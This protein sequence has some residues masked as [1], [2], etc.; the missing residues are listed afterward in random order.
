MKKKR[1]DW[2]KA[3]KITICALLVLIFIEAALIID[4]STAQQP[5][6]LV[7]KVTAMQ[8]TPTTSEPAPTPTETP[9]PKPNYFPSLHSYNIDKSHDIWHAKDPSSYITPNNEWVK[10]YS[11]QLFVDY[12]G[13]IKYKNEKVTILVDEKGKKLL[14]GYKPFVN[15]YVYDWEQ[16][17]SGNP[18][19]LAND[20][21]WA[22]ADYYLTHGMKGDC[23]EWANTVTSMM[24]SGEMSVWQEDKLVKQVIPTKAVL[25]YIGG[26]RDGWVEY[27][28]Y[29]KNWITSTSR[30][31]IPMSEAYQSTTIFVEKT[32]EFKSIFEF[33]DKYFRRIV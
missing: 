20:D 11:S 26:V 17:G 10:Y 24:L 29:N 14:D 16:F 32:N 2:K 7:P 23:D 13:R 4:Q 31:K 15:N 1:A 25:G 22:N 12:D 33:T 18:G 21:Y 5:D 30:E 9:Y 6:V 27:Q 19:S 3:G 8:G 28:A